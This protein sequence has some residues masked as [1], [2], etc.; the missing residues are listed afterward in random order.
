[1]NISRFLLSIV[2]LFK[3]LNLRQ[4]LFSYDLIII[5]RYIDFESMLLFLAINESKYLLSLRLNTNN[6]PIETEYT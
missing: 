1:M 2:L 4:F 5:L 6:K 3:A